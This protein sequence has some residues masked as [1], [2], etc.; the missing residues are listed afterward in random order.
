MTNERMLRVAWGSYALGEET[1]LREMVPLGVN[2]AKA[3]GIKRW[4]SGSECGGDRV[5]GSRSGEVRAQV[6][7]R[8]QRARGIIC[9]AILPKGSAR[10]ATSGKQTI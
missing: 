4:S 7:R 2:I 6:D 8:M 3:N 9:R 10:G 5:Y 1:G